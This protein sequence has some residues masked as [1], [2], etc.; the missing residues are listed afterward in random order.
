VKI[1]A[2]LPCYNYESYLPAAIDS[3]LEGT[4]RPDEIIVV[5]DGSTDGS[6]EVARRY[7]EVTLITKPNG[8][9]ASALNVGFAAANGD[10][11]VMLDADDT[12]GPRRLE[13]IEQAFADPAVCLA[14]HPL[15]IQG[16]GRKT[17]RFLLP[18]APLS[19]GDVASSIVEGKRWSFAITSGMAVRA[20][21]LEQIGPIPEEAFRKSSEGYLVRTLPFVGRIAA[22]DEPLGAYR[23]H[24]ASQIRFIQRRDATGI[25]AKLREHLDIADAEQAL[26]ARSAT[27]A[28]YPVSVPRLRAM[29]PVYLDYHR[30]RSR[31]AAPTRRD[32]WRASHAL[33]LDFPVRLA[34]RRV[35]RWLAVAGTTV[36]PKRVAMVSFLIRHDHDLSPWMR[37]LA[38]AYW[39]MR[40]VRSNLMDRLRRRR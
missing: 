36:L 32:A 18:H 10:V 23:A 35:T 4:R 14:W 11:V 17:G 12:A 37:L 3:L 34:H 19:R 13:W 29:D 27:M 7:P 22:T 1:S 31:L 28:G 38:R 21:A 40:A 5:D 24:T 30:W 9:M 8:G 16:H 26:L 6:A 33:E 25:A 20:S 39:G 15:H 2:V